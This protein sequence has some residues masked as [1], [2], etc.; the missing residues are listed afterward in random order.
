MAADPKQ[1][2]E[3]R[4]K[5]IEGQV[6]GVQQ[7]L[8]NDRSCSEV[9]QQMLA[10]RAA[11]QNASLTYVRAYAQHCWQRGELNSPDQQQALMDDLLTLI[12]KAS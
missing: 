8:A 9:L 7:M 5:R 10:I 11:V 6:R 3:N 12:A 1:D 2:L 4:L